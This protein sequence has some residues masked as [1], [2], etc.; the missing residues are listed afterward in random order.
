MD[1][2]E[3]EDAA[4]VAI[5]SLQLSISAFAG[6]GAQVD[7]GVRLFQECMK[8]GIIAIEPFE[9]HGAGS[10]LQQLPAY[11]RR[12]IVLVAPELGDWEFQI[13]NA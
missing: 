7:M 8:R 9:V 12:T 1:E 3:L 10:R 13:N 4:K 11:S 2:A 6:E 5:V